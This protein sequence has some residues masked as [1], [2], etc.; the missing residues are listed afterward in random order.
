MA[1]ILE[2]GKLPAALALGLWLGYL[3]GWERGE[4]F[5]REYLPER[6]VACY[7]QPDEDGHTIP[8]GYKSCM[9]W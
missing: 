5:A 9:S 3:V 2:H 8:H 6:N 4:L 7:V 1:E